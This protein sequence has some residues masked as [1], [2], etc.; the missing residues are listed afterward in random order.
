MNDRKYWFKRKRYGWG[1]TPVTW[2]GWALVAG[3]I[4]VA[5]LAA[6]LM[7]ADPKDTTVWQVIG[8][9]G[10]M[11]LSVATIF[12]FGYKHGPEPKWRWGKTIEDDPEEDL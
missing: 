2:Q 3:V 5:L 7:P 11:A 9:F 12:Y 8:Y 6:F 10:V 4:G 1:W